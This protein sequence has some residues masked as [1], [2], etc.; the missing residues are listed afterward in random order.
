MFN[1]PIKARDIRNDSENAFRL[2]FGYLLIVG[3]SCSSDSLTDFMGRF[4]FFSLRDARDSL[5]DF[6]AFPLDARDPRRDS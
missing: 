1:D 3:P 4:V 2:V 5:R 6:E